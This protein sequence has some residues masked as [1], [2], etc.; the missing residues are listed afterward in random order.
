MRLYSHGESFAG[1][2]STEWNAGS[3]VSP[4]RFAYRIAV[5][6]RDPETWPEKLARFV[7]SP[8]AAE[9]QALLVGQ[10]W[11]DDSEDS[12]EVV[13]TLVMNH[14]RLPNLRALFIAEVT[15]EECEISWIQH[16]DLSP[17]FL[18]F[19]RLEH[20]GVRGDG[21][22]QF[23]HLQ[24][25]T[26]RSFVLESGGLRGEVVQELASA[27]MPELTDFELWTGSRHYGWRGTLDD[28]RPIIAGQTFPHL[29]RL[30]IRNCELTD[31]V[32][33][34][35]V[36]SPL[37]ERLDELDVSL[38]TL[39]DKG[40]QI[41]LDHPGTRRLK[42]LILE[43]HFCSVEM[44]QA[45]NELSKYGVSVNTDD[46]RDLQSWGDGDGRYVAVGE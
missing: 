29:K 7:A 41:L 46:I 36:D 14:D 17:L 8:K 6:Y 26:L 25:A 38:G 2:R 31:E 19:P 9:T 13:E 24:H 27:I 21:G 37:F 11:S 23:G 1:Y 44:D 42:R 33:E 28:L 3:I 15:S 39:S 12:D 22:L 18:A 10:W 35:L 30:A 34:V 4:E 40:A 43:H 16:G 5:D 32:I 20:F 45:L